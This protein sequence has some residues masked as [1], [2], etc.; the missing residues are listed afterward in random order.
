MYFEQCLRLYASY[1]SSIIGD[2]QMPE[3]RRR[4]LVLQ[5]EVRAELYKFTEAWDTPESALYPDNRVFFRSPPFLVHIS[6]SRQPLSLG[7]EGCLFPCNSTRLNYFNHLTS[8]HVQSRPG[9]RA[10]ISRRTRY[11]L[12]IFYVTCVLFYYLHHHV[13]LY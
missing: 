6:V 10:S 7:L 2:C 5:P 4:V 11:C 12:F 3:C 1:Q 8:R 13:T 9:D